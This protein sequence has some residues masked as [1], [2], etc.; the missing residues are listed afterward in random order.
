[1][2]EKDSSLSRQVGLA[3]RDLAQSYVANLDF[4]EA[5]PYYLR[6]LEIHKKHLEQ[7]SVGVACARRLLGVI[8]F[9]LTEHEKASEQNELSMKVL[10][11]WG[12]S[13]DLIDLDILSANVHITLGKYETAI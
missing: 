2:L 12:Q 4:E 11:N 1:V 5:L 6:A 3:N 10:S 7:N 8:Y 13:S 9:G